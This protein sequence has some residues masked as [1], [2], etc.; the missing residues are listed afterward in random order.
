[1]RLAKFLFLAILLLTGLWV[2][3]QCAARQMNDPAMLSGRL[4]RGDGWT[5][6][7]PWALL[8]WTTESV[9]PHSPVMD[10]AIAAFLVYTSVVSALAAA[11][12][13]G[14]RFQV[15]IFGIEGWGTRRDMKR[16]GLLKCRGTVVGIH[17]GKLLTYD[18]PEHQIISGASRSGKGVGH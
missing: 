10:I 13:G 18:G 11:L 9:P 7:V 2:A 8:I 17:Q 5:L 3:T 6:Y 12:G 15:K 1:M 4:Y 14:G 16:A